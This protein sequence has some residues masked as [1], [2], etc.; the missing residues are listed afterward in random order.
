MAFL[1][2]I[3]F[4][5][6]V[7]GI[8]FGV[9]AYFIVSYRKK[10]HIAIKNKYIQ[11]LISED[12]KIIKEAKLKGKHMHIFPF[13]ALRPVDPKCAKDIS[14]LPY[15]VMNREEAKE[16]AK[17]AAL[18][19]KADVTFSITGIAGPDGGTQEKPVGLV[20]MGCCVC[21]TTRVKEF[22]FTGN[23]AKIRETAVSAALTM[24]R[25]CILEYYSEKTFGRKS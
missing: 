14:A 4:I 6:L 3:T 8:A 1:L 11:E 24:M 17:G 25:E 7:F 20:F 22:R 15:D 16:M 10:K 13:K 21:G 19:S 5:A 9:A 2:G 12:Q 23:R 18:I